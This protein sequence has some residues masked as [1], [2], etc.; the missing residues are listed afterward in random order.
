MIQIIPWPWYVLQEFDLLF[1]QIHCLEQKIKGNSEDKC[2]VITAYI[3][4]WSNQ[5][6]KRREDI[7]KK[8]GSSSH[9]EDNGQGSP[10]K[11]PDIEM[12]VQPVSDETEHSTVVVVEESEQS[13]S[14][15]LKRKMTES[16]SRTVCDRIADQC[17]SAIP[18]ESLEPSAKRPRTESPQSSEPCSLNTSLL[19]DESDFDDS[20]DDTDGDEAA[21]SDKVT[22]SHL[23]KARIFLRVTDDLLIM[24]MHW[25]NGTNREVMN[26]IFQFLKNHVK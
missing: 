6:R 3:N 19:H 8:N 15:F 1:F 4:T 16:E 10:K 23:V 14:S 26:Q 13:V 24:E 7:Q 21:P 11:S 20:A 5:R 12:T 17:T 18:E 2:L 22:P 25:I 9:D